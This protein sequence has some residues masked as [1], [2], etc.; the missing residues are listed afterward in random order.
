MSILSPVHILIFVSILSTYCTAQT[1]FSDWWMDHHGAPQWGSETNHLKAGLGIKYIPV[2]GRVLVQ[3]TPLMQ[4]TGSDS[5]FTNTTHMVFLPTPWRYQMTLSDEKGNLVE[6]TSL[7]KSLGRPLAT[8]PRISARNQYMPL[9][10][11]RHKHEGNTQVL[12]PFFLD[13]YFKIAQPGKYHLHLRILGLTDT[14]STNHIPLA[15]LVD[16][17]IELTSI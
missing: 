2:S 17:R 3:C 6:K 14:G 4:Y 1:N 13:D 11:S 9:G 7:G 15:Y 8:R 12:E 5:G 10:P 16:A